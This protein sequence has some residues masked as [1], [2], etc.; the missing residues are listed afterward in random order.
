MS[1]VFILVYSICDDCACESFSFRRVHF[2]VW[3]IWIDLTLNSIPVVMAFA[4]SQKIYE[5]RV[6]L[7]VAIIIEP[8]HGKT[9]NLH[10]R[11][12]RRRLA[13]R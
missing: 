1:V 11:K 5:D 10:M 4:E 2:H 8:P 12:Q 3:G 6:L 9:N 13:S 7:S